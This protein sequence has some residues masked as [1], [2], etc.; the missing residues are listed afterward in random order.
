MNTISF[1]DVYQTSPLTVSSSLPTPAFPIGQRAYTPDGREWV[2]V[3]ASGILAKGS[4]AV[5]AAVTTSS[6][7]CTS[8]ADNQGR[9]VYITN[10]AATWTIGQFAEAIGVISAGTGVGQT[11]KIKT[12]SATVLTLYPDTALTTALSVADSVVSIRTMSLVTK[13]AITSKLQSAV[14]AAQTAF[15]VGDCGWLITEGDGSVLA[16]EVLIVGSNFTTGA[17]TTGEVIKGITTNGSFDAQSLGFALVANAAADQ[18]TLVRFE[19]R[20]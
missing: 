13:A 11:F 3:Q 4:V 17:A 9:L 5:P 2:Y 20:G 16:G 15:A 6:A 7:A 18:G 10:A 19:I 8:S 12:N 14:G 1:Q